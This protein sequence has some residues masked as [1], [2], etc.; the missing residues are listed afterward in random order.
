MEENSIVP[1]GSA[2]IK[3]LKGPIIQDRDKEGWEQLLLYESSIEEYFNRI[4]IE[5]YL[6]KSDCFSFL[7]QKSNDNETKLPRLTRAVPLSFDTSLL[8]MLLRERLYNYE[9][10]KD[11]SSKIVITK[12]EI[13]ELLTPFLKEKLNEEKH[14]KKIDS[15][16]NNVKEIGFLRELTDH[17]NS[18][19]IERII[20]A[21]ISAEMLQ[22]MKNRLLGKKGSDDS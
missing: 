18:Y 19:K 2:I 15:I 6:D 17:E 12:D 1:Y 8:C 20:K 9:A 7:T 14:R 4:G 10:N 13:Y 11:E 22:E 5:L 16:I 3:L 21:K